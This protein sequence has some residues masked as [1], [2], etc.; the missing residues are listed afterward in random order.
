MFWLLL[1]A[2]AADPAPCDKP[3]PASLLLLPEEPAPPVSVLVIEPEA[4]PAPVAAP[5]V[6]EAAAPAAPKSAEKCKVEPKKE[7]K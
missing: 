2:L 5:V 6:A 7:A 1:P 3:G 4:S